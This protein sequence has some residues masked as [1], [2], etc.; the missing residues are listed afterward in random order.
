M[1]VALL[2]LSAVSATSA[3]KRRRARPARATRE[4]IAAVR[5]RNEE[6][7]GAALDAGADVDAYISI[8]GDRGNDQT[9]LMYSSL[10]GLVGVAKVLLSRGADMSLGTR[11]SGFTPLHGAAFQGQPQMIRLLL[12]H[13][14]DPLDRHADG[15]IPFHRACWGNSAR[16]T[17]AALQRLQ[18]CPSCIA[19]RAFRVRFLQPLKLSNIDM[20]RFQITARDPENQPAFR[21]QGGMMTALDMALLNP[22]TTALIRQWEETGTPPAGAVAT[23]GSDL[24]VSQERAPPNGSSSASGDSGDSGDED[25]QE[26]LQDMR[27]TINNAMDKLASVI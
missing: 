2:L 6:A 7:V 24:F 21:Q 8:D 18:A 20:L 27:W 26:L 4:L 3:P 16:H 25:L 14:A 13:G 22:M 23:W 12:E 17:E 11:D 1:L 19:V 15:F 10:L 9:G 5:A